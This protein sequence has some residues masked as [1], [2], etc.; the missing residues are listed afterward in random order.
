MQLL[1]GADP[2]A[3]VV[4]KDGGIPVSAH[5]LLPGTKDKPFPVEKGAVQVD[6]MAAEF[7][8]EPAATEDE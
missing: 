3:F 5:G 8:I 4:L 1:L 2:E 7:N 6:G